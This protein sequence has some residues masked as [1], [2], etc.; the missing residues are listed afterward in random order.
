MPNFL[1]TSKRKTEKK[2][3]THTH[4]HTKPRRKGKQQRQQKKKKETQQY[5]TRQTGERESER[6]RRELGKKTQIPSNPACPNC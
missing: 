2:K 3:H 6:A 1:L 4:T 5:N